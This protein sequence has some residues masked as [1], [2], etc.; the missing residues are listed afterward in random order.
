MLQDEHKKKK[1]L[2]FFQ[3]GY[4]TSVLASSIL[5]QQSAEVW[6]SRANCTCR[7]RVNKKELV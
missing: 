3:I 1:N 4:K 2:F 6:C 7:D 5:S